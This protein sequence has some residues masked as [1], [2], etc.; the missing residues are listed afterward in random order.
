MMT[1]DE[2][3]DLADKVTE[4][5]ANSDKIEVIRDAAFEMFNETEISDQ[6]IE[7]IFK[8]AFNAGFAAAIMVTA[9]E[10]EQ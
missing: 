1:V 10:G 3:N 5:V 7:D 9:S 2:T 6:T 4:Y 8:N